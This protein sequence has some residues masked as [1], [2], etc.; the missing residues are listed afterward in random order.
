MARSNSIRKVHYDCMGLG[1]NAVDYLCIVKPYPKLDDKVDAV[2]CSI[3][4][5]GP[6]P[7]AMATL[8][9][10]GANVCYAGKVGADLEGKFVKAQ[11]NKEGVDTRFVFEERKIKTARA[12][13]WVDKSTGKRTVVL[14]RHKNDRLNEN[15]LKFT[16]SVSTRFLHLDAREIDIN[17]NIARWAKKQGAEVCLDVGS[18][19][20][21]VDKVFP[22]VDHLIVSRGFA[23][24]YTGKSDPAAACRKLLESRF[25]TVVVT[26][27]EDGCIC[28][29]DKEIFHS[30]GFKVKVI[31]TTGAG[32]VFH[33][34]F[35]FGLLKKWSPKRV[36]RFANACAALKCRKLGGRA[37]IPRLKEVSDFMAD[38]KSRR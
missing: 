14:D 5:G 18:L 26:I 27:G 19:R 36:A 9:K 31:D 8:A 30:P 29:S 2:K 21:G 32:D 12:F 1:V 20:K 22:Y 28:A 3:Q 38:F 24:G 37:G 33:G 25:K 15:D 16:G 34:A 13:I 23:F 6:V 4:G 35:I 11:L 7:T 17:I 10:L